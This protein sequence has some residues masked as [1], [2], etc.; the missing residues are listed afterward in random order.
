MTPDNVECLA[1]HISPVSTIKETVIHFGPGI[2]GESI[3][4]VP[5]ETP[6]SAIVITLGID[7]SHYN[8]H[9]ATLH[10]GV[11][12]LSK[13]LRFGIID[14][15][16]YRVWPPCYP[17]SAISDGKRVSE[18]TKVPSTFKFMINL[19]ERFGYCET[20]QEGGYINGGKFY[21]ELDLSRPLY[22]EL[23]N[24]IEWREHFIH[25]ISIESI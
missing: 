10:I 19:K 5:I 8:R 6:D 3:L 22:L 13:S 9:D 25:Y 11:T 24:W 16:Q 12:D 23:L 2:A 4:R 15:K 17:V 21:N 7:N 1:S 18:G 14:V 20:A